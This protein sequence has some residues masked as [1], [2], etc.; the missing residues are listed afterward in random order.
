MYS[1]ILW[2]KAITLLGLFIFLMLCI[3]LIASAAV[4]EQTGRLEKVNYLAG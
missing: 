1:S 2:G 3:V 4:D